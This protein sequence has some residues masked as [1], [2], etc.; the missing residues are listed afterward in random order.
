MGQCS[1]YLVKNNNFTIEAENVA[2]AGAISQVCLG[3]ANVEFSE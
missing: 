1:Y 2:C 3:T